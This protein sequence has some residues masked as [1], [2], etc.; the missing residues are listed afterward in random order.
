MKNTPIT[1]PS[2]T[3]RE[4]I[5]TVIRENELASKLWYSARALR[6]QSDN[7]RD[8][9]LTAFRTVG[10]HASEIGF[11]TAAGIA[12]APGSALYPSVI[13]ALGAMEAAE[14]YVAIDAVLSPLHAELGG[15]IASEEKARDAAA[16]RA[17]AA[18]QAVMARKLQLE[19]AIEQDEELTRLRERAAAV[20]A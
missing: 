5:E 4:D 9:F 14:D 15:A 13:L 11:L 8:G 18:N 3:V 2:A 17:C 10:T 12:T 20:A 6:E 19:S 1:R 16:E 7:L